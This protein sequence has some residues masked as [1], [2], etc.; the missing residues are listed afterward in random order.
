MSAV[1]IPPS[2]TYTPG[3]A[4]LKRLMILFG[5]ILFALGFWQM[6]TSLWLLAFGTRATAEAIDVVKTKPGLPDIIFHNDAQLQA[7]VESRD[8]SYVFW[9]DF[10]FDTSAGNSITVRA[11]VGSQL[12][13]LYPLLDADG[14][15]TTDTICY[16]PSRPD[17][18]TF[19]D[20]ISIWFVPGV[21]AFVGLLATMIGS[22]LL[23]WSDKPIELPHLPAGSASIEPTE[24]KRD[25]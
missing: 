15:P 17:I 5:L 14:L 19:P 12:K 7:G 11:P 23:Y 18:V 2:G 4:Q 3:Y 1:A 16:D 8:R 10:Q 25:S 6:K 20:I 21:L 9:N 24:E 13:P 22:V